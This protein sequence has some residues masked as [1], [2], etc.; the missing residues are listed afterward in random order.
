M[1]I[2]KTYIQTRPNVSIP[3]YYEVYSS[4][5]NIPLPYSNYHLGRTI[6]LSGD[7]LSVTIVHEWTSQKDFSDYSTDPIIVTNIINAID[8]YNSTNGISQVIPDDE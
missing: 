8:T 2:T 5:V 3:F 1:P 7:Q 4:T 6:T